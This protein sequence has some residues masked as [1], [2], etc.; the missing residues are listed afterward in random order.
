[1]EYKSESIYFQVRIFNA[2]FVLQLFVEVEV[3]RK[4]QLL[5]IT[6]EHI[7]LKT[8]PFSFEWELNPQDFRK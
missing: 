4:G 2:I 1:M 3:T 5:L 8:T 7:N 6:R